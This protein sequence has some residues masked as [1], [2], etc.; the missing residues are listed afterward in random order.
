MAQD[1]PAAAIAGVSGSKGGGASQRRQ[2]GLRVTDR[3]RSICDRNPGDDASQSP[4]SASR[5][6]VIVSRKE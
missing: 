1:R 4:R 2:P 6:A 5:V 3:T